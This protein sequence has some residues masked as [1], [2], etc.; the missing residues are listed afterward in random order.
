MNQYKRLLI[1]SFF[2]IGL[3]MQ[4]DAAGRLAVHG[5]QSI[6][7][8][9][10]D[11]LKIAIADNKADVISAIMTMENRLREL[12][13]MADHSQG[14]TPEQVRAISDEGDRIIEKLHPETVKTIFNE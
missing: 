14:M 12:I 10:V 3:L 13:R 8:D 2:N 11:G 1:A 6:P 7:H 5:W 9:Q 4:V